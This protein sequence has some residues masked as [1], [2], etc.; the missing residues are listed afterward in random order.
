MTHASGLLGTPLVSATWLQPSPP[1]TGTAAPARAQEDHMGNG[2]HGAS[3]LFLCTP[4]ARGVSGIFV[5]T[6]LVLTGHQV[7]HPLCSL[8]P[9][10][11]WAPAQPGPSWPCQGGGT[12]SSDLRGDR[13]G[14]AGQRTSNLGVH[15]RSGLGRR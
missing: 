15:S 8:G 12:A 6:A 10:S 1:P 11:L 7:S 3:Q 14:L 5:W 13:R 9:C 4:L 2:S